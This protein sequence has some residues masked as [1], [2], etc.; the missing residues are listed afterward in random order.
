GLADGE[1]DRVKK[2]MLADAV[3]A[4]DAM[5]AGAWAL[6]GILAAGHEVADIEDWPARIEAVTAAD[7]LAA[8]EGVL[9]EER[10]IVTKLLPEG[11]GA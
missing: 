2:R 4:R 10:R 1:L 7:V 8:L 9:A 11:D 3:F 6:G 5:K